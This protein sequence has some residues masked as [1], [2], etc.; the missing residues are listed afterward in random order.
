MIH[1]NKYNPCDVLFG[2]RLDTSWQNEIGK[3]HTWRLSETDSPECLI[4]YALPCFLLKLLI[5]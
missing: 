5:K 4:E 3:V 1:L 2:A